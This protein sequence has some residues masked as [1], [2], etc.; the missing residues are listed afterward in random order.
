ME[1][2]ITNKIALQR[3]KVFQPQPEINLIRPCR[4]NDG[5]LRHADFEKNRYKIIF[6][7]SEQ[8]IH[9]FIP[10]SGAGS[11][12]FKFLY[13]FLHNPDVDSRSKVERFLNAIEDFAFF[14]LLPYE[15]KKKVREYD[16]N[17]DTFIA[18][19][20]NE[21]GLGLGNIP[22]GLV[23]FHKSRSFILNAFQEHLL[24]GLNMKEDLIHFHFTINKD[25]KQEIK[26]SVSAIRQLTGRD[27]TVEWTEQLPSTHTIAFDNK[28]NTLKDEEGNILVRPS[29]HGALLN[30]LNTIDSGIIFVKN[31]DNVQHE[32][33]AQVSI[34]HLRYLGGLLESFKNDLREALN[35]ENPQEQFS[36]LNL[37]Y[38]FSDETTDFS[39]F[40]LEKLQKLAN[41]PIRVCGM[42]RNE[43]QPGGGPFWVEED[44]KTTKQIVEKSQIGS[45]ET[46][47]KLMVQSKYF[48]PV[49]MAIST[50][51]L[52]GNKLDLMEFADLGKY[53]VVQK[54]Y[55]GQ[56]IRFMERPGLWNGSMA[57]WLSLF[58]EVPSSIFTPVKNVLDLLNTSH[59]EASS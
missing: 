58:V 32:S 45:N 27:F 37:Q 26:N 5:I 14:E 50:K 59:L 33:H 17:L 11:R 20:I 34:D 35:S 25:H 12:M 43:G 23:P 4:L 19:I 22:K 36:R 52:S 55:A 16:I 29:G 31:I 48:N 41:R 53:F 44:G 47:Y 49:I 10:A 40:S 8:K 1:E 46:M 30:N 18:Y 3:E 24:Q 38:Q 21:E 54:T 6:G 51:D 28:Q 15:I 2:I 39:S 42:V 7:N 57:H 13:E 56:S 9:F